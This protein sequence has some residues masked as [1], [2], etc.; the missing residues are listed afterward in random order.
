[1]WK[2]LLPVSLIFIVLL[3]A[4]AA[5]QT[6]A[7]MMEYPGDVSMEKAQVASA[8]EES[9]AYGGGEAPQ[10]TTSAERLVIK[11]ARLQLVVGDPA[12]IMDEIGKLAEQMNGYVVN[13]EMYQTTLAN[14]ASVPRANITIRVPV[15]HLNEAMTKIKAYSNQLPQQE[16]VTSQDV[17]SEYTD[18]TSR[19]RNLEAAEAQLQKIMEDAYRTEDV[20]QVYSQLTSVREQIEVIKGRMQYLAQSAALSAISVDLIADAAVQPISIGG[21]QP[22]GVARDAIRALVRTYQDI[23]DFVI[24]LVL[25]LIPVGAV[26]ILPV[27][28]VLRAIYRRIRRPKAQQS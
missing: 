19:L 7:P 3:G 6:P 16:N 9:V 2:R 21:W 5:R 14:G 10:N 11:N 20:L 22:T 26:I 4:C 13:A 25:Y 18:L 1:M 28:F 15:E 17:T 8:P 23:A 12:A 24:W 27:Y